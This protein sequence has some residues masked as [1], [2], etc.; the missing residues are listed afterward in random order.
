MAEKYISSQNSTVGGYLLEKVME[1]KTTLIR[2][3]KRRTT[4]RT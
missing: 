4:G 2:T 3:E 1:I